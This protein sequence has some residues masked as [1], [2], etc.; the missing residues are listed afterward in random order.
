MRYRAFISYTSV[1]AQWARWLIHRLETYRVPK[2]LVGTHGEH[3]LIGPDLGRFFRDRE[4]LTAAGDLGATIRAALA[5]AE[6]LVVVCSPAAARSRWVNAEVEAFRASG[7]GDR[8]L[9]FLIDGD[10]GST[11]EATACFPPA[12]RL[13]DADGTSIEPLAADARRHA[14]GRENA[15]LKL[16]AALLGVRYDLLA[17]RE[18]QRR[19]RKLVAVAAAS[20]AGMT[21]ALALAATAYVARND[22][23]RRQA[24]AEDI[25]GFMLGD[26][27]D[28]L[29]TVGRLD[30]MRAVDDK[31]TGYFATLDPRDL[32]DRALEEQ[33]RSLTGIG[34]VRLDEGNHSEAMDA[35]EEAHA[36]SKALLARAPQDGQRLYDLAQ[37]E[38]WIGNVAL[39]QGRDKDAGAWL[40]KYRDSALRLAAMDPANFDWQKE[41]AYAHHNLAVLD[42]KIGHPLAAEQAMREKM[43]LYRGWVKQRPDDLELRFEAADTASW[44]GSFALRQGRLGDAEAMQAEA[45]R[46]FRFN[47]QREPDNARWQDLLGFALMLQAEVQSQRGRMDHVRASV[48]AA[49]RITGLLV[50]LDDHNQKWRHG[51]GQCH[52]WHAL[53]DG[54]EPAEQERHAARAEATFAAAHAAEPGDV[55]YTLHWLVR[56][57]SLLAR[58]ALDSSDSAQARRW[59]AQTHAVLDPAWRKQ[60]SEALRIALAQLLV[61]DGE[62]ARLD[63]D[64]AAANASWQR[65]HDLLL[66]QASGTTPFERLDPLVRALHHLGRGA[67]TAHHRGRLVAA[68]YVGVSKFPPLDTDPTFSTASDIGAPAPLP[69]VPAIRQ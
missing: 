16:V 15:F 10:P 11:D 62:A 65:A 40:R 37:A 63:G 44:L 61:L 57:R 21:I 52:W 60:P 17:Q 2:R 8:V 49:C 4:E 59:L 50:A 32:S 69:A 24:Q 27:R 22:A 18:A 6:A 9:C 12:L 47:H 19:H 1:D 28:K 14:D 54:H 23:Q 51:M 48:D 25:L 13:P 53:L 66:D 67:E 36:R 42:D 7:R 64:A 55:I 30:L 46:G 26:L 38:F 20:L 68:G 3:G 43:A 45:V 39:V 35:F 5:E 33:A 41:V 34:Q 31:A 29:T 58:L 56:S